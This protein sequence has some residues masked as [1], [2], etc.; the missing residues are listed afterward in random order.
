M[1]TTSFADFMTARRRGVILG[2]LASVAHGTAAA[3]DVLHRYLLSI[4][5]RVPM[6]SLLGDLLWM[7][8]RGLLDTGSAGRHI[9]AEITAKGREVVQRLVSVPGVDVTDLN[10]G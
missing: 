1:S 9:T 7:A 3:D 6:D 5:L 2:A 4:G 10:A 8:E